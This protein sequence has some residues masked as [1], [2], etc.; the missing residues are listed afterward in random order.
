MLNTTKLKFALIY[1][2]C[3]K[4]SLYF[5]LK[6]RFIFGY[7]SLP[8]SIYQTLGASA[9]LKLVNR[10]MALTTSGTANNFALGPFESACSNIHYLGTAR[11]NWWKRRELLWNQVD[12]LGHLFDMDAIY[13]AP[14]LT[15]WAHMTQH[16]IGN[17]N[18]RAWWWPR[19]CWAH[20]GFC[21]R[22]RDK[23]D[24][25]AFELI[26][27]TPGANA[28]GRTW[29]DVSHFG[30]PQKRVIHGQWAEHAKWQLTKLTQTRLCAFS[31]FRGECINYATGLAGAVVGVVVVTVI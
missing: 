21:M 12:I 6:T 26:E 11:C 7:S 27:L 30:R 15:N 28:N 3:T 9:Q 4:I 19:G 20:L 29:H 31:R 2:Q 13:E 5:T 24:Q 1:C 17:Y 18:H 14:Q 25:H 16:T 23:C 8:L 10:L 22:H